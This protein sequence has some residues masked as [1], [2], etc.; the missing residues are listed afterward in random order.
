MQNLPKNWYKSSG[1]FLGLYTKQ[2]TLIIIYQQNLGSRKQK[3]K[4]MISTTYR[5][6]IY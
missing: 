5:S 4:E 2:V 6:L 3:P 1:L